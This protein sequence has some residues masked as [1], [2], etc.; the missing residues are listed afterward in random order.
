MSLSPVLNFDDV[1]K[2]ANG[3]PPAAPAQRGKTLTLADVQRLAAG[4]GPGVE[5]PSAL[6]RFGRAW[7]NGTHP[8]DSVVGL[9]KS[10]VTFPDYREL[11]PAEQAAVDA[12]FEKALGDAASPTAE[13]LGDVAA[14][15]TSTALLMGVTAGLAKGFGIAAENS[16]SILAGA[17]GAVRGAAGA[18]VEPA[19]FKGF[20]VPGGNVMAGAA[21]GGAAASALGLP[22]TAGAI[23]GGAAP[24]VRG[25]V[26]GAK[27][28]IALEERRAILDTPPANALPA[29]Q[30]ASIFPGIEFAGTPEPAAPAPETYAATPAGVTP[31]GP[32]RPPLASAA[33]SAAPSAPAAAIPGD[34]L[35][36]LLKRSLELIGEKKSATPAVADA[37]TEVAQRHPRADANRVAAADRI[38]RDVTKLEIE[39]PPGDGPEHD[40]AWG[41]LAQN[42]GERKGYTPSADTRQLVR[43][44]VDAA[45]TKSAD[46][47]LRSRL[48]DALAP[49][50]SVGDL[51]KLKP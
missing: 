25:A 14:K 33:P 34:D 17:K 45:A 30:V 3:P 12:Q 1:L 51:G 21:G 27:G 2:L 16:G 23:V 32:I 44:R 49:V 15:G 42:L 41:A 24:I 7:W 4:P 6:Q 47:P 40:A 11:S 9:A 39:L 38:A 36:A 43:E 46:A 5:P 28:A 8:I 37:A 26:Q 10:L 20:S 22:R 13:Y 50:K 35:E 29:D 19:K 48:A 31:G 18:L